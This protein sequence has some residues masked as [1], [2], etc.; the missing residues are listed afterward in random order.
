MKS[1][2]NISVFIAESLSPKD[3]Y[4]RR[5]DGFAANEVLKIQ[6]CKTDYR[7]VL[8]RN[9]LRRAIK[10]AN[11]GNY[12]I[13]H[14]SCHGDDDGIQLANGDEISWLDLGIMFKTYANKNRILVMASCSGGHNDLTKALTKAQSIFGY[15]IG[16]ASK[17]GVGFT[18]SCIA[19]SIL[20]RE[21][22]ERGLDRSIIQRAIKIINNASEGD[23]VY[24]R[25][26]EL[27]DIYRLY[28]R[29]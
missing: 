3:Y 15:V 14:L 16:S 27:E 10:E 24:R 1:G 29:Q 18:D 7:I 26:D 13:F 12:E 8:T 23:F 22:I 4:D 5:M 20:Y 11:D 21:I 2:K 19:W 6:S 25:W 28:P 17:D 9:F